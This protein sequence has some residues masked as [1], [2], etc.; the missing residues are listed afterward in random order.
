[1]GRKSQVFKWVSYGLD[2]DGSLWLEQFKE[3][4]KAAR[5]S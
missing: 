5:E 3:K 1:M 2:K 4:L